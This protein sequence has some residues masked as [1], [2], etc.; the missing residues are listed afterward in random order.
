MLDLIVIGSITIHTRMRT[1]L[2]PGATN[3]VSEYT[4]KFSGSA[5]HVALNASQLGMQVGIIAP[6]GRDA[7][8]LIDVLRRYTVD[9]SHVVLSAEKNTNMIELYT[10]TRHYTLHYL[11]ALQDLNPEKI[12]KEYVRKAKV[13]HMCFPDQNVTDY[14]VKELRKEKTLT[15]VDA[16]FSGS[17]ADI[18]FTEGKEQGNI[19]VGLDFEKGITVNGKRIPIFRG[20]TFY[21]EGVKDAFIAAF[22]TRYI[23]SENAEYAALYGSCAAFLC[24]QTKKKILTCSKDVVDTL[25]DEKVKNY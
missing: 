24:S 8:G 13:V 7:V 23:K 19:T 12:E 6:V 5:L 2:K 11:G 14:I 17:N 20:D 22:L 16:A 21:E 10:P 1:S 18:V 9:Y 15:S 4:E 3:P 25:F